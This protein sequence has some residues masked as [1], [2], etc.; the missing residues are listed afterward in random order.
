MHGHMNV[1]VYGFMVIFRYI[2]SVWLED[3]T[4]E[5]IGFVILKCVGIFLFFKLI[6]YYLSVAS[7]P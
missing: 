6:L 2:D 7:L 3:R 1:K 5:Q 4:T